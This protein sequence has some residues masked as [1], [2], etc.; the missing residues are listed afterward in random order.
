MIVIL[1]KIWR[2]A[3]VHS[4]VLRKESAVSVLLIIEILEKFLVVFFL[5]QKNEQGTELLEISLEFLKNY[6]SDM[7]ERSV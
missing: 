5:R 7:I 4:L 1:K 3:L 2:I 6:S